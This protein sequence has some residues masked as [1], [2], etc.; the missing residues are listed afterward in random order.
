M[1]DYLSQYNIITIGLAAS[2]LAGL[3]TGL[4]AIPI[5]FTKKISHKALDILLG[6]AAGVMLAATC[7]SLIIPAIEY[8]GHGR[9]GAT[10]AVIGILLGGI[11][12]DLMDQYSPHNYFLKLPNG[13]ESNQ[14]RKVWLFVIAITLHNFP[15]GL[16][17]GVGF[18]NGDIGNGLTIAIAI[19]LQNIPEG[20][21]VALALI[22]EKY[23]ATKA[24]LIALAT[25]LVEPIGGVI[26]VALVHIASPVLPYAL[27]FAAGAMLYVICN[28][29][30]PET[31]KHGYERIATYGLMIG[32]VIMMFLDVSLG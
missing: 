26:G 18:G 9:R 11:F 23:S 21:A 12:L 10:I 20:L 31:Q 24:F 6:F 16:A 19:G 22:R 14:L 2:I 13:S 8:G 32:F 5:F 30:I 27:A 3:C 28:E 15:E 4:G 1:V 7:F 29:I 17:V 25:G